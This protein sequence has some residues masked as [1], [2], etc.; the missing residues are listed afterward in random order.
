MPIVDCEN[1]PCFATLKCTLFY[2]FIVYMAQLPVH[3]KQRGV[4]VESPL[5]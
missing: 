1:M 2:L 5:F 4:L 3:C